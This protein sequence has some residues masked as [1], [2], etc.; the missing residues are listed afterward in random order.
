[1]F[2][3]DRTSG[4]GHTHEKSEKHSDYWKTKTVDERL[5]A[6]MYLNSI[7]F[8]FDVNNPPRIDKTYFR[9]RKHK[10]I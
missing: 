5:E 9:V 6:L 4:T 10:D 1:M 2:K 3:L 7:A 8:G